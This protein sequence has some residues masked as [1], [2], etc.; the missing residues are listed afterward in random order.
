M[1]RIRTALVAL[2]LA[3][4]FAFS[5]IQLGGF[6]GMNGDTAGTKPPRGVVLHLVNNEQVDWSKS[7][8]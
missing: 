3:F 2:L 6:V 4:A 5:A 7:R 8:P 1:K